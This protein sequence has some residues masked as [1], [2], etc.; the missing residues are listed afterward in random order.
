MFAARALRASLKPLLHGRHSFSLNRNREIVS[1]SRR[2][3]LDDDRFNSGDGTLTS[4][5]LSGDGERT[6]LFNRGIHSSSSP[7]CDVGVK[8]HTT[9]DDL[10]SELGSVEKDVD[11]NVVIKLLT[12]KPESFQVDKPQLS[13]KAKGKKK[14]NKKKKTKQEQVSDSVSKLK[15]F[16][17]K[18][19]ASWSKET[20]DPPPARN[21]TDSVSKPTESSSSPIPN[22]ESIAQSIISPS[23]KAETSSNVS[24]T[25]DTPSNHPT[26]VLVIRISN[27]NSKTTDSEIHSRC[28]S[29]GSLEGL[30]RVNEDSVDVSFRAR[31]MNEANSILKK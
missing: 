3:V 29:I 5:R 8:G 7:Q 13:Q 18:P 20:H 31:N 16:T 15:L 28:L 2:V 14:K 4:L 30:A 17:E 9:M 10:F 23:S 6:K 24:S 22:H 27:L 19:E 26:S 11:H 21:V 25:S 1:I 12:T